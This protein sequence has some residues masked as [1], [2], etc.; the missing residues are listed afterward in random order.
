[1]ASMPPNKPKRVVTKIGD[2]FEVPIS[3]TEKKYFQL[4]AFDLT[5][6]NSDVIRAFKLVVPLDE[7]P[8]IADILAS[9]VEFYAHC[10]TSWG[11]KDGSWSKIG[12]SQDIGSL[13]HILFRDSSD[14]G[15][16]QVK[17]S[18][19]WSVWRINEDAVRVGKL[20][21]ENRNAEIGVVFPCISI[22]ERMKNGYYTIAYPSFE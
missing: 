10:V 7:S 17:V 16:P 13:D 1:M 11:V 19:K 21:G 14:V 12:K 18:H 3:E 6:L 15:N 5:M 22:V 2:V 4:I 8:K 9:G 20:Q